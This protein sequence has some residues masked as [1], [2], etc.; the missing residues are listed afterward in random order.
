LGRSAKHDLMMFGSADNKTQHRWVLLPA[1]SNDLGPRWVPN[2]WVI[3]PSMTQ[4]CRVL[5]SN[6]IQWCWVLLPTKVR[7]RWILR[8]WVLLSRSKFIRPDNVARPDDS[9]FGC[10]ANP[11]SG[12]PSWC[13]THYS[14]ALLSPR[15]SSGGPRAMSKTHYSHQDPPTVGPASSLNCL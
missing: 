12:G 2:Y 14:W 1:W 13:K 5:L 3:L 15:S 6:M 8:C 11:N 4:W 10:L 9:G 7:T